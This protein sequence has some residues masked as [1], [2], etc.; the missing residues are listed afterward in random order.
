MHTTCRTWSLLHACCML[1]RQSEL[2][3]LRAGGLNDRCVGGMRPGL[4]IHDREHQPPVEDRLHLSIW[5][6]S[7]VR[8]SKMWVRQ[9]ASDHLPVVCDQPRGW[10]G[11]SSGTKWC[12]RA[13]AHVCVLCVCVCVDQRQSSPSFTAARAPLRAACPRTLARPPARAVSSGAEMTPPPPASR[14]ASALRSV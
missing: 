1:Q 4:G 2:C 13:C 6:S 11:P 5:L 8:P 12:V 14:L 7:G 10:Q 3:G 9:L